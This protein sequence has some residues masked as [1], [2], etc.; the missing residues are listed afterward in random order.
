MGLKQQEIWKDIDGYEGLY[1]ISNLG[2]VKSL[3]RFVS[4]KNNTIKFCE[5]K[6]LNIHKNNYLFVRL[7]NKSICKTK[8]IHK[9]VAQ[10]F[11]PNPNN[12]PEVNH[13][14]ENKLNNNI[15][16]LEWCT[17]S[18]NNSYGSRT[19]KTRKRVYQYD[20]K[21][22]IIKLWDGIRVASRELNIPSQQIS[23]CCNK[24]KYRK[25]AGGYVWVY[26]SEVL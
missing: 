10:A 5:G 18:Y 9:L 11:I 22:N 4:C 13:K 24:T 26:E 25:T 6:L 14:D 1:Q 2:N 23:Q 16:N 19:Q 15:D 12:Y 17:A 21:G 7:C 20:L 8:Y 3:N